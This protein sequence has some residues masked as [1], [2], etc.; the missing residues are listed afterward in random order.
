MAVGKWK[1]YLAFLAIGDWGLFP[2]QRMDHS[3]M[4][5]DSLGDNLRKKKR[6][7]KKIKLISI[8]IWSVILVFIISHFAITVT[9]ITN[10]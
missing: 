4:H 1:N 2:I 7:K 6:K 9:A 5:G 8:F 10:L 3:R